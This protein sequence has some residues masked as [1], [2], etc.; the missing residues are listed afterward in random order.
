M[1]LEAMEWG[2]LKGFSRQYVSDKISPITCGNV[3]V[4]RE[5]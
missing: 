4:Q 1:D 2:Y 3:D 5:M